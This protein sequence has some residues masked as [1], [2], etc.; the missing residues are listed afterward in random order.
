MIRI[1]LFGAGVLALVAIAVF[2]IEDLV[3]YF[4]GGDS[5]TELAVLALRALVHRARRA[6]PWGRR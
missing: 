1:A 6:S 4:R 3:A 2:V 5:I